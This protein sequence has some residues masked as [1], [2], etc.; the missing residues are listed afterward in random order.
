MWVKDGVKYERDAIVDVIKNLEGTGITKV[1]KD[2]I[3]KAI[4]SRD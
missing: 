3:I 1:V 4:K 2:K